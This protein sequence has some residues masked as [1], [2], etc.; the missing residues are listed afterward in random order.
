MSAKNT[1]GSEPPPSR[2]Y[3]RSQIL[4]LAATTYFPTLDEGV[5]EL[6]DSLIRVSHEDGARAQQI[7]D[8]ALRSSPTCPT[9]ATFELIS[10]E[11]GPRA[12]SARGCDKCKGT[13]MRYV[14]KTCNRT[15]LDVDGKP[16]VYE[17]YQADCQDWCDCRLREKR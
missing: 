11:L 13:G 7:I 9:P 5:K 17:S 10:S 15:T 2:P 3:F 1:K 14:S 12:N 4:R 16:Y 8:E 6:V